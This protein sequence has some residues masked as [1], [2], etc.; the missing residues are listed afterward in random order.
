MN[1]LKNIFTSEEDG[2]AVEKE[3]MKL[4]QEQ[5]DSSHPLWDYVKDKGGDIVVAGVSAGAPVIYSVIKMYF[6]SKGILLL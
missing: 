3:I 2:V 4:I 6:A 5:I 1:I